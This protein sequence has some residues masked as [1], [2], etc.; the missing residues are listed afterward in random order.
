MIEIIG[1]SIALLFVAVL[2]ILAVRGI[3]KGHGPGVTALLTSRT[4]IIEGVISEHANLAD[5]MGV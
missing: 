2:I 3:R 5:V 4:P 1:N